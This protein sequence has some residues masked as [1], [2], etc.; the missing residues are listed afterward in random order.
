MRRPRWRLSRACPNGMPR[1]ASEATLLQSRCC[2]RT[3]IRHWDAQPARSATTSAPIVVRRTLADRQIPIARAAPSGAHFSRVPSLEASVRRPPACAEP[4]VR[5]GIRNPSQML[6]ETE[7]VRSTSAFSG[8]GHPR[9]CEQFGDRIGCRSSRSRRII[10][11]CRGRTGRRHATASA[12]R[13]RATRHG[14]ACAG[15]P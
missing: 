15:H 12:S 14:R 8:S 7:V 5:A 2:V 13:Y 10:G 1:R 9:R 4:S 11:D 6:P 3:R